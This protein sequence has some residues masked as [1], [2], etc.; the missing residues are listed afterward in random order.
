M[1]QEKQSWLERHEVQ[2]FL[3]SI[4]NYILIQ[5]MNSLLSQS[6][7]EELKNVLLSHIGLHASALGK[8]PGWHTSQL[9]PLLHDLHPNLHVSQ[10]M[11]FL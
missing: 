8:N 5:T 1:S 9:N 7:V 2:L 3:Q 10:L 11:D 6:I 4:Y